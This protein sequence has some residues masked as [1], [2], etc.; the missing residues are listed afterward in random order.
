MRNL[1][2]KNDSE[3]S[4]RTGRV[5]ILGGGFISEF[6]LRSL[7]TVPGARVVAVCD[8]DIGKA[9]CLAERWGIDGAFSSVGEMLGKCPIDVVHVL[10]PPPQH[11]QCVLQCLEAGVDVF[12]EK[13]VVTST[14]EYALLLD[15]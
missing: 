5:A 4:G 9:R 10:T 3:R 15:A 13:P 2:R 6:H 12:L 14:D 7:A 1:V 11:A 8:V